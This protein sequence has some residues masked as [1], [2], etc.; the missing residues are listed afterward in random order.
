[1]N[2]V[3][4][5]KKKPTPSNGLGVWNPVLTS[6]QKPFIRL[7]I[8]PHLDKAIAIAET[9]W[10]IAT[11]WVY[12]KKWNFK[13]RIPYKRDLVQLCEPMGDLLLSILNL[14]EALHSIHP[15]GRH[16]DNAALWFDRVSWEMKNDGLADLLGLTETKG[17]N[18]RVVGIRSQLKSYRNGDNPH[19]SDHEPHTWRLI[20]A[21]LDVCGSQGFPTVAKDIWR[22][23]RKKDKPLGFLQAYSAWAIALESPGWTTMF[24]KENKVYVRS[25]KGGGER[26]LFS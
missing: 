7:E 1:M 6:L 16:Y 12:K 23:V 10:V 22:G 17:K 21:A 2:D 14:T 3:N 4:S 8:T 15:F 20:Q 5:M 19:D 25:G 18:D 26:V 9:Y 13:H 24:L 11:H